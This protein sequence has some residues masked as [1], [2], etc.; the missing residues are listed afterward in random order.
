MCRASFHGTRILL[1]QTSKESEAIYDLIISLYR[2]VNG[3]WKELGG[4]MNVR[5]ED[6]ED[7]LDYASMFLGNVGNY[8]STGDT[9][10]I[11]RICRSTLQQLCSVNS[12][13]EALFDAASQGMY[14]TR[15]YKYGYPEDIASSSGYYPGDNPLSKAEIDSVQRFVQDNKILP[16][17]TRVSKITLDDTPDFAAFS[18][19]LASATSLWEPELVT[20]TFLDL[21]DNPP[22]SIQSGDFADCLEKVIVELQCATSNCTNPITLSMISSLVESFRF[23]NHNE[24]KAAQTHWVLDRSPTVETI[25][26][27]IE[28]YQDPHGVRAAWEGI[29]AIVNKEQTRKF[30]ELVDSS[31]QLI[32]L[33]P[34]N[35]QPGGVEDGLT[36]IFENETFQKPD[37]TSVDTLGFVKSESPAGLNLPNFEEICQNV[38]FKNLQ[39]GNVNNANPPNESMPFIM[40]QEQEFLRQ[41]REIAFEVIV[42]CHELLGHGSGRLL[43]EESPGKFN[44]PIN[45]RPL[46]PLT[47]EPISSWYKPGETWSNVF[48]ADAN[49]I[50]ECRADGVALL[51]LTEE[52]VLEIFGYTENSKYL[53]SDALKGLSRWNPKT[54]KWG[55]SHARGKFALL[56]CLMECG[57]GLLEI[58]E[59]DNGLKIRL[60]RSKIRSHAV[61]ALSRFLLHLQTYKS[62][63]NVEDGV[64]FLNRYT[65]VDTRF[66]HY[67]NIVVREEPLRTQNIQPAN[68]V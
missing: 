63:A 7:F 39:F 9:K 59:I 49:A 21:P 23:G 20:P 67:R 47:R 3:D 37:F 60:D 34:W 24:F 45:D 36:S 25:I 16:E 5:N 58:L 40:E 12:E 19:H 65:D 64:A 41:H 48:G 31:P 15:P 53:A 68:R 43:V 17:N 11:P 2:A 13:T 57:D 26:G 10:F 51:L 56:K 32:P 52:R 28:T 62:T 6:V 66:A 33:L 46:D 50:E 8:R 35:G 29:V 4:R 22:I 27:F 42:A 55:Q 18:L 61:P 1:Q 54:K 14:S 30:S 44:F 38:G